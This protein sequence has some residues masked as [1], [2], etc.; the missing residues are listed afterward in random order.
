L[1][2][3]WKIDSQGKLSIFKAGISGT[4]VHDLSI[5][6]QDIIYG[7]Y[8]SYVPQTEKHLRSVW[9]YRHAENL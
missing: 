1:E 5:D 9:K 3:V 6:K 4:H 2:A 8:N 7:W